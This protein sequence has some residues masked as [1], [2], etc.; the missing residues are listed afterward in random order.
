[1]GKSGNKKESQVG[2]PEMERRRG[3]GGGFVVGLHIQKETLTWLFVG[4]LEM[5]PRPNPQ[6]NKIKNIFHKISLTFP[7]FKKKYLH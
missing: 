4:Q 3:D 2:I 7:S 1:M 5:D 6:K